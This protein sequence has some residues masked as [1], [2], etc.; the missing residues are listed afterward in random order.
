MQKRDFL[1]RFAVYILPLLIWMGVIFI[2]SSPSGS[3]DNTNPI[4]NSILRG[5]FPHIDRYLTAEQIDQIDV[6]IRKGAHVT[7]YAIL[8]IL[9]YRAFRQ[10]RR[11]F[12]Q[13]YPT[14]TLIL[15][16]LY[17]ASDEYH[18]SFVPSRGASVL[19][20][21][22]D[23]LGV[24]VGVALSLWVHCGALQKQVDKQQEPP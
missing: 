24:A 21:L 15:G 19:D 23:V 9:A 14:W 12:R 5:L 18:Q 17:A 10:G 8:A 22:I 20:A 3:A 6:I 13:S 1:T 11:E 16:A 2:A 4:V 7:E